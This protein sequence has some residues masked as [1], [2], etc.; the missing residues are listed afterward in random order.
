MCLIT[1]H[2]ARYR[3][4]KTDLY[5]NSAAAFKE[6]QRLQ[7][8]EYRWSKLLGAWAGSGTYAARGV[9]ERFLNPARCPTLDEVQRIERKK[10]EKER[11]KLQQAED[12]KK[13]KEQAAVKAK[14]KKAAANKQTG[15]NDAVPA[16]DNETAAAETPAGVKSE[17]QIDVKKEPVAA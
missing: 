13:A 16:A 8:G 7:S 6:L 12:E 5:F 3:D 4:P 11:L 1:N 17:E 10:E 14:E 9:P 15:A 2:T